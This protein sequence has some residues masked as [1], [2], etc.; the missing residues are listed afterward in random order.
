MVWVRELTRE[1][2]ERY[3]ATRNRGGRPANRDLDQELAEG[4]IDAKGLGMKKQAFVK[5]WFKGKYGRAAKQKDVWRYVRRLDRQLR[6]K[7]ASKS[8][9]RANIKKRVLSEKSIF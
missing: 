8:K 1:D 9:S 2:L 6:P 5:K 3:E 4:W 7:G